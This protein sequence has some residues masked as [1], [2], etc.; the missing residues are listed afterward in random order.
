MLLLGAAVSFFLAILHVVIVYI[1]PEAYIFFGGEKLARASASSASPA[2]MTLVLALI[3]AIFG[4]Y[5]LSGA[6]VIR[7]LPLLIV[8]LFAIGGMYAFRGLSFIEQLIQILEDPESLPL[9][10]LVYSLISLLTGL[11]YIIGTV[12]NRGWLRNEKEMVA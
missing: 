12:K 3:H 7:R 6:G 10:M 9:R 4:C 8:G 11:A 1:G 2:V 5:G